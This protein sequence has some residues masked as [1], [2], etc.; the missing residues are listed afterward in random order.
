[1]I[2]LLI[3]KYI[4]GNMKSKIIRIKKY[5]IKHFLHC[6]KWLV[7]LFVIKCYAGFLLKKLKKLKGK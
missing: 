2:L 5:G 1:M 4:T 6:V 7:S 3:E